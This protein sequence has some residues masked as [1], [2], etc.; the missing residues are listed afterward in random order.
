MFLEANLSASLCLL[1]LFHCFV[2]STNVVLSRW[3]KDRDASLRDSLRRRR[4]C[5]CPVVTSLRKLFKSHFVENFYMGS[6]FVN[7]K[8]GKPNPQ[9]NMRW[10]KLSSNMGK[11]KV[12]IRVRGGCFPWE[13]EIWAPIPHRCAGN[14]TPCP[15]KVEHTSSCLLWG[16][17]II[18]KRL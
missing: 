6:E 8:T 15:Q 13:L 18:N 10:E 7:K 12:F 1:I 3:L 5:L 16:T 4:W 14:W 9:N 17:W 2:H 11:R